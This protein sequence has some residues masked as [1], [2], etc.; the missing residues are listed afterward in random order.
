MAVQL[1]V[2][3]GSSAVPQ[4]M[5]ARTLGHFDRSGLRRFRAGL[6][7]ADAFVDFLQLL[8]ELAYRFGHCKRSQTQLEVLSGRKD[9]QKLAHQQVGMAV[10]HVRGATQQLRDDTHNETHA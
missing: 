9:R 1:G 8:D 7:F 2:A 10:H 4:R 3:A 6:G 5:A